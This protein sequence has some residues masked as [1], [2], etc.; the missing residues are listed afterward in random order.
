MVESDDA[1]IGG[2]PKLE[3]AGARIVLVATAR[4]G[5]ARAVLIPNAQGRM[6][7]PIPTSALI[8]DKNPSCGKIGAFFASHHTIQHNKRKYANTKIGAHI[9]TA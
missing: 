4:N 9:N 2:K 3:Q 1:F 7:K 8:T 5:Q 6:M